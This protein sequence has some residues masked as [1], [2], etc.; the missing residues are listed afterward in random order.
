MKKWMFMGGAAAIALTAYLSTGARAQA[1]SGSAQAQTP[2]SEAA[3]AQQDAAAIVSNMGKNMKALTTYTY[4]QR[5]Q[6]AYDGEL[7]STT[8]NQ[9]SFDATGKPSVLQL[10]VTPAGDSK[11]RRLGHRVADSKKSDI[12]ADVKQLI[13][14]ATGYLYPDQA[15]MQKL[16]QGAVSYQAPNITLTAKAFQQAGDVL[17][18]TA[19]SSSMARTSASVTT[20]AN[21]T[22]V[23]I[24][25]T[26]ANLEAG[27][28]YLSHYVV[29]WP[30]EKIQ[31]TFDTLNYASAQTAGK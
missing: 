6:M 4:Q 17:A 1:P 23:T 10:S 21:N 12:E 25:A 11:E 26:Y 24:T 15:H 2:S 14:L 29:A 16:A 31:L 7:K 28:N 22:P 19:A 13:K 5:V 18:L 27:L 30:S 9:I 8:L 3:Q 20:A